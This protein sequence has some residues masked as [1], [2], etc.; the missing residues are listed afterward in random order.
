MP[1]LS[2]FLL[3][4]VSSDRR[5]AM[6]R[7]ARPGDLRPTGGRSRKGGGGSPAKAT[8]ESPGRDG[9]RPLQVGPPGRRR[10]FGG[11]TPGRG[12]SLRGVPE[13]IW[14]VPPTVADSPPAPTSQPLEGRPLGTDGPRSGS[15]QGCGRPLKTSSLRQRRHLHRVLPGQPEGFLRGGPRRS[16]RPVLRFDVPGQ[17]PVRG[18]PR[19]DRSAGSRLGGCAPRFLHLH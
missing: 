16:P 12:H 11:G 3:P 19:P 7:A 15:T 2:G 10:R 8:R 9:L 13:V 1:R 17:G 4:L 6:V 5:S 14:Q 18:G